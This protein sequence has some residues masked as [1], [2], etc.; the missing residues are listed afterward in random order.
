[1]M[2]IVTIDTLRQKLS[3]RV[4]DVQIRTFGI[5]S[6]TDTSPLL[7]CCNNQSLM[8]NCFMDL[9]FLYC[10]QLIL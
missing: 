2:M 10:G 5:I 3:V 8:V 9:S 1:M 4:N 6:K 7:K